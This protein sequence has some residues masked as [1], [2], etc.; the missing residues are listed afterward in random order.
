MQFAKVQALFR[1]DLTLALGGPKHI[2]NSAGLSVLIFPIWLNFSFSLQL[3]FDLDHE[4][5]PMVVLAVVD[6]GDGK[7]MACLQVVIVFL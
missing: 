7:Q 2:Y 4:V 6:E 5:Y 1:I 3:S